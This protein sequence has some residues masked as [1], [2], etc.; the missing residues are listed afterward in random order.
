MF[1]KVLLPF[2]FSKDSRYAVRCLIQLPGLKEAVLLHVIYSKR[3][4]ESPDLSPLV[5][6]ARLRLEEL[7]RTLDLPGIRLISEIE[8]I[9][10]GEIADSITRTAAYHHTSLIL[11][12]RKGRGVI[13]TLLLGSVASDVLRRGSTDLLLVPAPGD[14]LSG[15]NEPVPPFPDLFSKVMVCTD[16]SDPDIVSICRDELP[17]I[18]EIVLFHAV[19]REESGGGVA[20]AVDTAQ[21]RLQTLCEEFTRLGIPAHPLIAVGGAAEEILAGAEREGVSLILMKARGAQGLVAGLIGST[22]A[23]VARHTNHPLLVLKRLR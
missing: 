19:T 17:W 13:E 16:F 5:D 7:K 11:M 10:G 14:A 2:D 21:R 3:P 18:R 1:E 6:Y 12:G 9:T 4:A 15:V 22:T 23:K 20:T 8:E